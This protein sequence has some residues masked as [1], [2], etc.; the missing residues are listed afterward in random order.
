MKISKKWI[1]AGA[2]V[3]FWANSGMTAADPL[4]LIQI[5]PGL[6]EWMTHQQVDALAQQSHEQGHCG[7]F[8]DITDYP[9]DPI[10]EVKPFFVFDQRKPSFPAQVAAL[11]KEV[12][13]IRMEGTIRHLSSYQN[14]YY[15]SQYGAQS[16]QWIFEQFEKEKSRRSDI[17]VEKIQHS[18]QQPSVIARIKGKNPD[19]ASQI[20]VIGGH[21]D[22]INQESFFPRPQDRAPGADDNASG[23]AVVLE[24]F[25]VLSQSGFRPQR[26]IEFMAYAGEERGLLGSQA[27]ARDYRSKNRQVVG[28]MQLDMTM[29]HRDS[30]QMTLISDHT[31]PE[32]NRF[33][34]Q[35]IDEYVKVPWGEA[36]C[37]YACS[38]HAS[39][40]GS[41]YASVFPF[42]SPVNERN[43][44]IHTTRD[45]L[46]LLDFEH[47]GHFARLAIAFAVELSLIK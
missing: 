47:G 20:V 9:D 30:R 18:F 15:Q 11:I 27:I 24:V 37:G 22:S 34:G 28:V 6:T 21:Q 35:L 14:R 4:R 40:T 8:F 16:A 45:T 29:F 12:S 33:T 23:I 3:I 32:L 19:L 43:S 7:G 42:E 2:V 41:G 39:W 26:T 13:A 36:P 44:K 25:R 38:D 31:Q 46:D 1:L 5:A 10:L 17:E